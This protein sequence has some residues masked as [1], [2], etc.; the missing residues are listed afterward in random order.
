MSHPPNP[1]SSAHEAASAKLQPEA[2]GLLQ[3]KDSPA[4]HSSTKDSL[5]K[6]SLTKKPPSGSVKLSPLLVAGDCAL[7]LFIPA[8]GG[9]LL[10]GW[11]YRDYGWSALWPLG[12]FLL[13]L[14]G[15]FWNVYK[16]LV[17]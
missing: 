5:I 6:D 13:G 11:L 7:Q 1:N 3:D 15:G 14:L 2:E 17:R 16:R 9:L 10:G 12:L 8:L 4:K